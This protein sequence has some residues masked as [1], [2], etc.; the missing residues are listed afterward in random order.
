[1]TGRGLVDALV[2]STWCLPLSPRLPEWQKS[3]PV[4]DGSGYAEHAPRGISMPWRV[5]DERAGWL[6]GMHLRPPWEA[7]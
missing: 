5:G 6:D 7:R 1:M 2:R 4:K 3:T